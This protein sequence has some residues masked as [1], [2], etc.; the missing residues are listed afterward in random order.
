VC[1]CAQRVGLQCSSNG[2]GIRLTHD[3]KASDPEEQQRIIAAGGFVNN[4][5]VLGQVEVS[6][7]IGD[8]LMK[9]YI[10]STPFSSSRQVD[11]ADTHVVLACDGVWDVLS[12]D[13]VAA[14]VSELQSE[15]AETIAKKVLVLAKE[16]K[17]TDNLS[18]VVLKL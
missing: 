12:D 2:K 5:R 3:H 8:Q 14:F 7:S 18:V 9:D 1:A 11:D 4:N 10:V 17:S 15:S 16:K 6:R 13:E